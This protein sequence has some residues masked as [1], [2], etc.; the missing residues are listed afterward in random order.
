V[1]PTA[2][3]LP[4]ESIGTQLQMLAVATDPGVLDPPVHQFVVDAHVDR[5]TDDDPRWALLD[6][7]ANHMDRG[8][9]A[10]P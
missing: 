4:I 3:A 1:T 6:Q 8:D 2:K 10:W 7:T 9:R 5:S